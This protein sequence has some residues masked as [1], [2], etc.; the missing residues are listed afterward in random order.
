MSYVNYFAR[1][2]IL[3]II[4]T[5]ITGLS[6]YFLRILLARNFTPSEFGLFFAIL[7]LPTIFSTLK[8]LGA[9][10]PLVKELKEALIKKKL[11]YIKSL[12][13]GFL[14]LELLSYGITIIILLIIAKP[15]AIYYYKEPSSVGLIIIL[16]IASFFT[17]FDVAFY[18]F[19]LAKKNIRFISIING[20]RPFLILLFSYIAITINKT[21]TSIAIAYLIAT[22]TMMVINYIPYWRFSKNIPSKKTSIIKITKQLFLSG[23]PVLFGT[24]GSAILANIDTIILTATRTLSEVG[25]YNTALP[26]ASLARQIVKTVMFLIPPV[27]TELFITDKTRFGFSIEKIQKY[28]SIITIPGIVILV[29]FSSWILKR[30]FGPEYIEG[31]IALQILAFGTLFSMLFTINTNILLGI[32]KYMTYAKISLI[33]GLISLILNFILSPYMGIKGA[34]IANTTSFMVGTI[35]S[36][37]IIY[38]IN[39]YKI[40]WIEIIKSIFGGFI[41][42]LF[43]SFMSPKIISLKWVIILSILGLFIYT[44]FILI[45]KAISLNEIKKIIN[46]IKLFKINKM[47]LI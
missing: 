22:I 11:S 17:I 46:Q 25:I 29:F 26:T 30:F 41:M 8:H 23:T 9:G 5:L 18:G 20:L 16:I 44:L 37:T 33:I 36:T 43:I 6:G 3:T 45:T 1:G 31:S 4:V 21:L 47:T 2:F 28:S 24:I 10:A 13:N 7:S 12:I 32:G 38:K 34:A 39:N 40:P 35:I 15:L 42:Y 14:L 19:Y 27:M